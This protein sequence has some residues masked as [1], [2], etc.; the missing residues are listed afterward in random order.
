[1]FPRSSDSHR[2]LSRGLFIAFLAACALGVL[3]PG[4]AAADRFTVTKTNVT[5]STAGPRDHDR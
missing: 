2:A 5:D 3:R 1:M 4:S